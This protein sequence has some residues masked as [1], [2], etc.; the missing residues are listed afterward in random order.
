MA[1]GTPEGDDR[2]ITDINVTPLVDVT[3]VL[4]IIFMVTASVVFTRSLPVRLPK[5]SS[6]QAATRTVWQVAVKRNGSILLNGKPMERA[7]LASRMRSEA[8]VNPSLKVDLAADEGLSYGKVVE[9]MDMLK[10]QG[11]R[12][13]AL[14]V[15]PR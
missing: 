15:A 4:L 12:Q 7:E 8:R 10:Q 5:S 6:G 13:L 3:L 2:E 1:P 11:V 9:V 14:S